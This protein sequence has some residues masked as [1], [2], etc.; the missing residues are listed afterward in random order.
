[1]SFNIYFLIKLTYEVADYNQKNTRNEMK[2]SAYVELSKRLYSLTS[3][4]QN[5]DDKQ[6]DLDLLRNDI[7]SFS[8]TMKHLFNISDIEQM[9]DE[10]DDSLKEI[11][12]SAFLKGEMLEGEDSNDY[13]TFISLCE[14]FD[15]KRINLIT[16]L[17]K[18]ILS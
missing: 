18:S 3:I 16:E 2:Q 9:T 1:M 7:I 6:R 14:T 11:S 4:I 10:I 12:E 15:S 17:Q 8:S 13:K 5:S